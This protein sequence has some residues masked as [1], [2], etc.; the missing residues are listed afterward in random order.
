MQFWKP[1]LFAFLLS[2]VL[3][4]LAV[5]LFPKMGLLDKP[6]KYGLSRAPIPYYGGVVIFFAFLISVLFFISLNLALIGFLIAGFLI[7]L[8]GFLDDLFNVN[9]FIRLFFQFLAGVILFSVGISVFWINFPFIGGVD[10]SQPIFMGVAISSLIFTIFWIMVI[11]NTMN[12]IDG[13]SGLTV[14]VAFIAGLTMFFLSI[15]PNLHEDLSSQLPVAILSLILAMVSFGFLFFEFPKPKI[16]M[17]DTGST[18]LGFVIAVLAIFSGGKLATTFLVLGIPIL[19]MIWVVFRRI[20]NGQKFWKG[21]MQ[22]LHHRLLDIGFSKKQVVIL[23]YIITA[24][25]GGSAVLLS[26]SQQ[27]FFMII[28]LIILMIVL[29]FAT[30][31]LPRGSFNKKIKN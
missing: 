4:F 30:I 24:F 14:G 16:L 17:G 22:H 26:S 23:Y 9:P 1:A 2:F 11:V 25:L 8:I 28:A 19:D 6:H 21:D 31:F 13:V 20:W 27:K 12:F 5:K 29:A 3:T 18:F 10:L 7:V 15:N